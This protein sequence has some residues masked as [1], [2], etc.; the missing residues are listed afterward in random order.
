M[1]LDWPSGAQIDNQTQTSTSTT[2]TIIRRNSISILILLL[3][4]DGSPR[5]ARPAYSWLMYGG[6]LGYSSSVHQLHPIVF[7]FIFFICLD[8]VSTGEIRSVDLVQTDSDLLLHCPQTFPMSWHQMTGD[9]PTWWWW[10]WSQLWREGVTSRRWSDSLSGV[11]SYPAHHPDMTVTT[12][13]TPSLACLSSDNQ[14]SA[15]L[16]VII[17]LRGTMKTAIPAVQW[18]DWMLFSLCVMRVSAR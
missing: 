17:W 15:H 18:T 12:E 16:A 10:R 11:L 6:V 13:L 4:N 8:G 14:K 5:Y 7:F 1:K 3:H 9:D 2:T